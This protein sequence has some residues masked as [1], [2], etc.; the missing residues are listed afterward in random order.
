[1]SDI[2]DMPRK[3]SPHNPPKSTG[4]GKAVRYFRTLTKLSQENFAIACGVGKNT[5]QE[6]ERGKRQE[7]HPSTI[8][9]IIDGCRKE[10]LD[11]DL[12]S[13]NARVAEYEQATQPKADLN[14]TDPHYDPGTTKGKEDLTNLIIH[15]PAAHKI[16]GEIQRETKTN[17]LRFFRGMTN[18]L[19]R[20]EKMADQDQPFDLKKFCALMKQFDSFVQEIERKNLKNDDD[21]FSMK[22]LREKL[23]GFKKELGKFYPEYKDGLI[24]N[25]WPSEDIKHQNLIDDLFVEIQQRKFKIE[26]IEDIDFLNK[27]LDTLEEL[28]IE[29]DRNPLHLKN[30]NVIRA[31]LEELDRDIFKELLISSQLLLGTYADQ[32]APGSVFRDA[33]E[34]VVVPA[35]TFLMGSADGKGHDDERPQHKVT[36]AEPFAVGRYPV[37]FEEWDNYWQRQPEV[38]NPDDEGWGRGRRPVMKV[39]WDD[40][41]GFLGWLEEFTDK[42]Y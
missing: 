27:A 18:T 11:I 9:K 23:D 33:P 24:P 2:P 20:I 39:S 32:L 30:I 28:E 12:D 16:I 21:I 22:S 3:T 17:E 38:H 40:T 37:T 41:R 34:M 7:P 14:Y 5:L 42:S 8:K 35:G 15:I 31:R 29:L 25:D 4:V 6:I 26:D 13:F 1:M 19:N 10:G 36:I